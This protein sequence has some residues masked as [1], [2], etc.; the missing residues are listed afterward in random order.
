MK[1]P[2][3]KFPSWYHPGVPHEL[4][5]A[6]KILINRYRV[7][8]TRPDYVQTTPAAASPAGS[9]T[10]PESSPPPMSMG[11]AP[12]SESQV[13]SSTAAPTDDVAEASGLDNGS[14]KAPLSKVRLLYS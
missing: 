6:S 14:S 1:N 5:Q 10:V 8:S 4:V 3:R 11:A 12:P 7:L 9:A 2:P 13:G